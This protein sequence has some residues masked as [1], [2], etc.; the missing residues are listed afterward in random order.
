MH[1]NEL[2]QYV[3]DQKGGGK[4]G[5]DVQL[6]GDVDLQKVDHGIPPVCF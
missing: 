1:A 5:D 4:K 2:L 6:Q 3:G